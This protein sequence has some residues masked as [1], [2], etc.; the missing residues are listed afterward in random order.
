MYIK[1]NLNYFIKKSGISV[2]QLAKDT[3]FAANTLYRILNNQRDS[4]NMKIGSVKKLADYFGV[5]IED[6][7]NKDFIINDEE[8]ENNNRE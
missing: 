2:R 6:F 1:S 8:I 5:E 4:A 7:V 3:D